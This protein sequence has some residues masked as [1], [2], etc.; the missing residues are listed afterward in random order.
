[1]LRQGIEDF[2]P[3]LALYQ[4]DADVPAAL[5]PA[6]DMIADGIGVRVGIE[7]E[8]KDLPFVDRRVRRMAKDAGAAGVEPMFAWTGD[9]F[10]GEG[11][12]TAAQREAT[13]FGTGHVV[14]EVVHPVALV[15]PAPGARNGTPDGERI[16]YRSGSPRATMASEKRTATW[17]ASFV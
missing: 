16:R 13:R 14:V 12:D 2:G 9:T 17:L 15:D 6:A 7:G 11:P 1:M 3:G 4:G 10:A 8:Q 5:H